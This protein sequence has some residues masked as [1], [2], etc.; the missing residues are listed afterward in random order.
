[1]PDEWI[2]KLAIAGPPEDCLRA[3]QR[4]VS[5]GADTVVLVPLP[6]RDLGELDLFSRYLLS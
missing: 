2:D 5:A 3:I 4:L 6:D 1:M